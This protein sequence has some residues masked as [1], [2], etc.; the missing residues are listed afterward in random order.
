MYFKNRTTRFSTE[1]II[2]KLSIDGYR[3]EFP[4][5]W[6]KH[7]V[8][9][10]LVFVSDEVRAVRQELSPDDSDLQSVT[11]QIGLGRE[12]KSL[13]NIFYRE[14]TGAV[15]RDSSQN[16][17]VDRLERQ[18]E[19]WKSLS[20][21]NRDYIILG[22][23]NLCSK[24]WL[25]NNYEKKHLS[26]NV[27]QF[28][29]EES[30][31]QLVEEYTRSE[32]VNNEVQRSCI[33]HVITNIPNKCSKPEVFSVG[34][35]DHLAVS[36]KKYTTELRN[37]PNTIKKRSYKNFNEEAFLNDLKNQDFSAVLNCTDLNTAALLFQNIYCNTLN[38][39]A[40]I[41]VIQQRKNYVPCLLYTSPSPRD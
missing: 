39:H 10:V 18:V 35:S 41:K 24:S 23:N 29:L 11:L 34:N 40:P 28:L 4:A 37:I 22:D 25:D 17:Q 32:L 27:I 3:I 20:E 30:A 7:G 8:A 9:R 19:H 21:N 1:E 33:D 6:E 15:S 5:S 36:V 31:V 13:V 2:K 26:E 14:W 16:A 12:K 38:I